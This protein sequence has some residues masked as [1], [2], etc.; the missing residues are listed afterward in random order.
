ME[1]SSIGLLPELWARILGQLHLPDKIVCMGVCHAFR[2]L[3]HPP[4]YDTL[5]RKVTAS[6]WYNV[7]AY[8]RHRLMVT[9]RCSIVRIGVIGIDVFVASE[10]VDGLGF[11]VPDGGTTAEAMWEIEL[12][13]PPQLFV[14]C[15]R[16]QTHPVRRPAR[17][18]DSCNQTYKRRLEEM[19][20][21]Q[22]LAIRRS[23]ELSTDIQQMEEA[24]KMYK[25]A[26]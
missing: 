21:E 22:E 8:Y 23:A 10:E 9:M 11:V 3:I 1:I 4:L 13:P 7:Y 24:Y 12:N 26:K 16:C 14:M 5:Y 17:L 20:R 19:Q 2:D 15:T 18:C 6:A 25:E